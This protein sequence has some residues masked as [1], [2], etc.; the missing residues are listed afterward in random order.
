MQVPNC[1]HAQVYLNYSAHI[2]EGGITDDDV[3][4]IQQLKCN[5]SSS[6]DAAA[7]STNNLTL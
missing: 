5:V 1:T 7:D 4:R 6:A 2:V 3:R